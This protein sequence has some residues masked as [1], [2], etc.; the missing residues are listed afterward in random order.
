MA[1]GELDAPEQKPLAG[2]NATFRSKKALSEAKR[3]SPEQMPLAG[4]NA[5]CRSNSHLPK[6]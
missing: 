2:A 5:T 1:P 6:Q 4:A 3:H